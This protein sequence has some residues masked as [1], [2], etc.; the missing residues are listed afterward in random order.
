MRKFLTILHLNTFL[1]F[2]LACFCF[3]ENAAAQSGRHQKPKNET[4]EKV[5]NPVTKTVENKQVSEEK[6]THEKISSLI[7]VGEIQRNTSY[8][9]TGELDRALKEVVYYYE[10]HKRTSPKIT[11]EGKLKYDEAKERAK[12]E[13]ENYIL[14][15]G[16]V[17]EDDSYGNVRLS[18][19]Q[20]AILSPKTA[21]IVTRGQLE[22]GQSNIGNPGGILQMPKPSGR[23]DVKDQL[24]NAAYGIVNILLHGGW[25]D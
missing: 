3:I 12:K 1:I 22:P 18:S 10:L 17:E 11:R 9:A 13:T 16:F 20:Y 4:V 15:L 14:W 5:E 19:V 8:Y 2:C 24:R 7:V 23:Q 6:K 25:L 21:E